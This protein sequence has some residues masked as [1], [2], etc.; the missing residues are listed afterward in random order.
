M[1]VVEMPS[2]AVCLSAIAADP[3]AGVAAALA[4]TP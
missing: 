4:A 2:A 1:S 3:A